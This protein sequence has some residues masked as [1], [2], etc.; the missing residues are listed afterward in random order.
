MTTDTLQSLNDELAAKV[1]E[2]RLRIAELEGALR[3]IEKLDGETMYVTDSVM[4]RN[5][6][7]ILHSYSVLAIVRRALTAAQRVE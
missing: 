4:R 6:V 3:A 5:P 2:Q 7:K 1:G